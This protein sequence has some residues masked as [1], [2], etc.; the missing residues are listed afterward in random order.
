MSDKVKL[1]AAELAERLVRNEIYYCVSSLFWELREVISQTDWEE[2][3]NNLWTGEPDYE[4]AASN[5]G[6]QLLKTFQGEVF[7]REHERY[8]SWDASARLFGWDLADTIEPEEGAFPDA[9]ST[10]KFVREAGATFEITLVVRITSSDEDD[11]WEA[12]CKMHE[13]PCYEVDEATEDW[14][15]LC[16]NQDINA[17]EYRPEVYEHW[18]ISGWLKR[19]LA[20]YGQVVGDFMGLIVWGRCCTGQ[21]IY[22][23][24]TIQ[25]VATD[26]WADE[27]NGCW[28][29][30]RPQ[31]PQSSGDNE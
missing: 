26:L 16:S 12:L 17:D 24:H 22:L 19:R 11:A 13:I 10:F 15:E 6:W 14:E 20:D 31:I 7:V 1:P 29:Y 18:L 2:E 5:E 27:W 23:D 3:F 30:S 8:G 9:H 25:R 28:D 21:A 4:E